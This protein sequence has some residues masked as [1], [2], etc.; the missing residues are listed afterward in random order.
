MLTSQI[1]KSA[2][3]INENMSSRM[4]PESIISP[5]VPPSRFAAFSAGAINSL[6]T[7]SK[8]TSFPARSF[9]LLNGR[10][11]NAIGMAVPSRGTEDSER[12]ATESV[13]GGSFKQVLPQTLQDF[14]GRE[15]LNQVHVGL[16]SVGNF[17]A[18]YL[19]LPTPIKRVE[20]HES[21]FDSSFGAS[22]QAI[23][24]SLDL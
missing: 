6:S 7:R 12:F 22:I 14:F 21:K 2:W 1:T 24:E 4:F 9:C 23:L 3:S 16:Y 8:S 5:V 17:I 10:I 11:T 15:F 13:S 20:G 19:H 18:I